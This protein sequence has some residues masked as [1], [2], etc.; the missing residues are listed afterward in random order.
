MNGTACIAN[1]SDWA[2]PDAIEATSGGGRNAGRGHSPPALEQLS[3]DLGKPEA[4]LL[5]EALKSWILRQ[6]TET[7]QRIASIAQ[8]HGTA[9]PDAIEEAI[10]GGRIDGHPAWEDAFRLE[11]LQAYQD[12]LRKHLRM[13]VKVAPAA[14]AP[15]DGERHPAC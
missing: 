3:H 11:G 9:D 14:G 13:P 8:R 4:D 10:R 7:E 15:L 12:L 1:G 5:Q 2:G 6:L